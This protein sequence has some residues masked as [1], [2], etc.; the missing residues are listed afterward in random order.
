MKNFQLSALQATNFSRTVSNEN[1]EHYKCSVNSLD[2]L[3]DRQDKEKSA[4]PFAHN[5]LCYGCSRNYSKDILCKLPNH[6]QALLKN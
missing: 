1:P 2:A 5:Q 4:F 6:I 3:H